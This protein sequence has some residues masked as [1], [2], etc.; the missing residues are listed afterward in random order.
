MFVFIGCLAAESKP[1]MYVC[2]YDESNGTLTAARSLK[3]MTKSSFITVDPHHQTVYVAGIESPGNGIAASYAFDPAS[4][5]LECIGKQSTQG[6]NPIYVSADS[7]FSIL[8]VANLGGRSISVLPLKPGGAMESVSC[9]IVHEGQSVDP[10]AQNKSRPHSIVPDPSSRFAIVSDMG[11]DEVFTYKI[12]YSRN[13]LTFHRKL[14]VAPGSGPRHLIFH[15]SHKCAY[16]IN[17]LSSTISVFS[18]DASEGILVEFQTI[19][20]LPDGFDGVSKCADI[21]ISPCGSFVYGSNRGHDS[22]AAYNVKADG[23]LTLMDHFSAQGEKPRSLAISPDGKFLLSANEGS[24]KVQT[25]AVDSTGA[26][27]PV[28]QLSIESNPICIVFMA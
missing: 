13:D 27:K 19:S 6:E 17:E 3:E 20:T 24:N 18:Y 15:P 16:L 10:K 8:F 28:S 23:T 9:T 22:I 12:D 21:Q 26:L 2:N 1:N 7:L 25:F 14:S 4:A 11:T 5:A